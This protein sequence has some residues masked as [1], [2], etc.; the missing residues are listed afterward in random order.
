MSNRHLTC[1]LS[2]CRIKKN[3]QDSCDLSL[4]HRK[5]SLPFLWQNSIY[6]VKNKHYR[7]FKT[8]NLNEALHFVGFYGMKWNIDYWCYK[9]HLWWS[10]IETRFEKPFFSMCYPLTYKNVEIQVKHHECCQWLC[11]FIN[12]IN[13]S[14]S[15]FRRLH[16]KDMKKI[17]TYKEYRLLFF[18]FHFVRLKL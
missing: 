6:Q 17:F 16:I 9:N 7:Y 14:H 3:S 1:K 2:F 4:P 10:I 11:Y 12:K 13:T 15:L 8:E 18:S 5:Q